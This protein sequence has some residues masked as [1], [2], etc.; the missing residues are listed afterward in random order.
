MHW[1]FYEDMINLFAVQP[2]LQS[3]GRTDLSL[4]GNKN[5]S[6]QLFSAAIG[7][8]EKTLYIIS[9]SVILSTGMTWVYN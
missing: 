3:M 2:G 4:L 8:P 6:F 1:L 5:V 9:D 7:D